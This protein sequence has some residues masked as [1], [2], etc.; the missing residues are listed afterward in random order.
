MTAS[1]APG[2]QA[3][4]SGPLEAA[5][6][7]CLQRHLG[8]PGA[9]GGAPVVVGFSGGPDSSALLG[10]FRGGRPGASWRAVAV[11]VDHGLDDGSRGRALAAS[12]IAA[13]LSVPFELHRAE[14]RPSGRSPEEWAR[15]ERYRLLSAAARAHGAV[16]ILVAHHRLDQAETVL[17]RM[18][19]GSGV[20]GLAAM[21]SASSHLGV[22]LLRPLLEFR[23]ELLA[24]CAARTG[25]RPVDDPT[26]RSLGPRRNL[27]RR[28]LLP[29]LAREAPD[30]VERLIRLAAAARTAERT[31]ARLIDRALLPQPGHESCEVE[32]AALALLPA[33]LWPAGLSRLH[34]LAGATYP[35]PR[36]ARRE[37]QRQMDLRQ[38]LGCSVGC[39]CGGGWRWEQRRDRLRLLRHP[40]TA[41]RADNLLG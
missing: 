28:R 17:L 11:H 39:D 15:A 14:P 40:S 9:N 4:S 38:R 3:P 1:A 22:P 26:N 27:V 12:E 2:P 37:L 30:S 20:G 6:D 32:L 18:L 25:I 13:R 16:A 5:V 19:Q 36:G 31:V 33:A 34:R 21:S 35:P 23:P 29:L 10:V 7:A 8:D 41:G 24:S